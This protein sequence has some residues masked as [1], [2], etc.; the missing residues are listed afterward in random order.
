MRAASSY[1]QQRQQHKYFF[2]FRITKP[3]RKVPNQAAHIPPLV[4]LFLLE[5]SVGGGLDF[6]RSCPQFVSSVVINS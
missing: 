2:Y 1:R 6:C 3:G 4:L 5:S